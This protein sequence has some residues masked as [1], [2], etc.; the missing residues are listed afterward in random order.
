MSLQT[1][2]I[3]KQIKLIRKALKA[4]FLYGPEEIHKLKADLRNL[5]KTQE[6]ITKYQKNGFGQYVRQP[7]VN[8]S[9]IEPALEPEVVESVDVEVMENANV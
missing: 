2:N 6:I 8:E 7:V 5:E 3:K 9:T 4:E 1:F